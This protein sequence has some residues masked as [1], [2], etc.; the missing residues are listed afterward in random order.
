MG[1]PLSAFPMASLLLDRNMKH[2][3][4]LIA[5]LPL[6][7]GLPACATNPDFDTEGLD[8][9]LTPEHAARS[10]PQHSL[11]RIVWGGR[12]IAVSNTPELRE[13]EVL[14]F[15]LDRRDKPDAGVQTTGRFFVTHGDDPDLADYPAGQLVTV[16]GIITDRR[17]GKIGEA[18]YAYP[19]VAA[20]RVFAW[21]DDGPDYGTPNFFFG[22]GIQL[23]F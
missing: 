14:G 13:I 21:P 7:C 2:A 12:V 10:F 6:V 19:V 15:P 5:A 8:P 23:G 18:P 4:S 20:D 11:A 1:L 3:R 17:I 16:S 22:F 9:G